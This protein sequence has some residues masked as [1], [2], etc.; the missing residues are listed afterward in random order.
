MGGCIVD[1]PALVFAVFRFICFRRNDTSFSLTKP[2]LIDKICGNSVTRAYWLVGVNFLQIS[3][4]AGVVFS[5]LREWRSTWLNVT[6]SL[7]RLFEFNRRLHTSKM[8]V[9]IFCEKINNDE[10]NFYDLM[11]NMCAHM[12][13]C[14]PPRCISSNDRCTSVSCR[15][16]D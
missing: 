10:M 14:S 8:L 3:Q 15:T 16:A 9:F 13:R 4:N 1:S 2:Q 12:N 5:T 11:R 7:S 6:Y